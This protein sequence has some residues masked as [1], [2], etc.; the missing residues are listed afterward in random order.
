MDKLIEK[1]IKIHVRSVFL[2]GLFYLPDEK[3]KDKFSD[4][5]PTIRKLRTIAENAG[6]TLAELS[7]QWV[8][9]LEQVDK[10][11]IGV[12]NVEQLITHINTLKKNINNTVFEEA[13]SIKYENEEVLN[14]SLWITKS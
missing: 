13:L 2:Q 3:L 14:P 1:N 8:C 10:V 7:L 9:S 11:I 5:L 12:D 6:L 4:V